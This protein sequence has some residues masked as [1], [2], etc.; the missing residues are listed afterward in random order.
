[1][2]L[3][4]FSGFLYLLAALSLYLLGLKIF[5]K[6]V[7][8]LASLVFIFDPA[9]LNYATSGASET[10]FI[11]ELI[12]LGYLISLNTK[13][14]RAFALFIMMLTYFTRPTALIYIGCFLLFMIFNISKTKR[15]VFLYCGIAIILWLLVE[16]I[17]NRYA[18]GFIIYSPLNIF[19]QSAK[20]SAPEITSTNYLRGGIVNAI[21]LKTILSK[22]FYNLYNFYKALPQIYSPYLLVFYVLSLFRNIKNTTE[23][24]LRLTVIIMTII[25]FLSTA[26]AIPLYR[27]LHPLIPLL[28]LFSVEELYYLVNQICFRSSANR[29]KIIAICLF[30]IAFFNIGTMAGKIFLDARNL[31]SRLNIFQPPVYVQLSTILKSNTST[32]D[33]I[34]TNLDTWGT[35]YGNRTT[36]W[37][38]L[39]PQQLKTPEGK[40]NHISA[41]FLTSYKIDDSNY[42]MGNEWRQAFL[43]PRNIDDAF[44]KE[45]YK[46]AAEFEIKPETTYEKQGVRAVLFLRK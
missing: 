17:I 37:Y 34:I 25:T 45:N 43:N 33:I 13:T 1:M 8:M 15:A 11:L 42:Y 41:I 30:L 38:P 46:L 6:H 39:T 14:T 36:I 7:G 3:L 22:I 23:R 9:I 28:Y 26:A 32:N 16:L 19:L 2:L 12:V 44:L 21:S 18:N 10:V 27:Y 29:E 40:L 35:W 31:K 4:Y 5:N 20:N 24:Y